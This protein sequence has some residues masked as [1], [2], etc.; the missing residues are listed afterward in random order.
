MVKDSIPAVAL[1]KSAGKHKRNRKNLTT[2][3]TQKPVFENHL[4]SDKTCFTGN[5]TRRTRDE[6]RLGRGIAKNS[7]ETYSISQEMKNFSGEMKP[8]TGEIFFISHMFFQSIRT[9][10]SNSNIVIN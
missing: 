3:K 8:V 2:D 7:G 1:M 4:T 10:I 6:T 5:E 9:K